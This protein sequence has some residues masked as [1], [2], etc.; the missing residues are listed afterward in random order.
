MSMLNEDDPLSSSIFDV[1]NH[2]SSILNTTRPIDSSMYASQYEEDPWGSLGAA[3]PLAEMERTFNSP[4][5]TRTA[6]TVTMSDDASDYLT[7]ANTLNGVR[8]PDSYSSLF[9]SSQRSGRVSLASLHKTL[10][11]GRLS[12][13]DVE[14][15]MQLVVPNSASDVTRPEFYGAL[16]LMACAQQNIPISLPYLYKHRD[17]IN[18]EPTFYDTEKPTVLTDHAKLSRRQAP[19]PHPAVTS[20]VSP[21]HDTKP[22][23][24]DANT[25]MTKKHTAPVTE[26]HDK[27]RLDTR[28]WFKQLEEI[29]VTIA[30]EREGFI[31]KHVNYIVESQKRSSIVLR[32]FSDFWWLQE[33]LLRRYPLR[34]LAN[35][36]PKKLGGRDAAFLEKRRKGLSRFI[37]AIVR[38]PVLRKDEVVAKFLS[39]PSELAAWRKQN[40]PSLDDEFRRGHH[41]IEELARLTP[42]N[43]DDL[44]EKA[45]KRA[46]AAIDHYINLCLIMER[47]IRRMH[48]QATDFVRFSISLNSLAEAEHRYHASECGNCQQIVKGY[49]KVA[50]HMQ[51]ESNILDNQVNIAADG[52]LENLKRFRD[53]LV[54][55]RDMD[56]R[57][58]S[59]S[60]DQIESLSKRI[61]KHRTR[62]NQIK[63]VPGMEAEVNKLEEAVQMDERE[64]KEQRERRVF[65]RFCTWSEI[66]YVHKQQAF[67]SSIYRDYVKDMMNFSLKSN[68]NWRELETPVLEMPVDLDMFD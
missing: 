13:I 11:K 42:E 49:E 21:L 64:M 7:A 53:L 48:G 3:D 34:S 28:N 51:R 62:I 56:E 8:L 45:R 18:L 16:A 61:T 58:S 67:I 55:F 26:Q 57:R 6:H 52:V 59:L 2:T 12:A 30:P 24:I 25:G 23:G 60:G 35:L 20:P 66:I 31:F 37:N 10:N 22:N 14:K 5:I 33:V 63:G 29:K 17:S 9:S 19:D 54:S 39:E 68:E 40:P 65:Q 32:R 38:H 4:N 43:L 36:P 50:K 27:K 41:N 44:I 46:S 15:I 1:G 47:M